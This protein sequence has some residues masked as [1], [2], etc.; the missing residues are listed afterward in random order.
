M[1]I[2]SNYSTLTREDNDKVVKKWKDTKCSLKGGCF[3]KLK[4]YTF[5]IYELYHHYGDL[6]YILNQPH[7]GWYTAV[8]LMFAFWMPLSWVFLFAMADTVPGYAYKGN[9][10]GFTGM[11]I[12]PQGT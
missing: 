8:I 10:L 12:H 4:V 7:W 9:T 5:L 2:A 11:F 1:Y 3:T 6:F